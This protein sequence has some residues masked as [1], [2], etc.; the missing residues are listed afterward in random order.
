MYCDFITEASRLAVDAVS[1][2]LDRYEKLG[3]LYG[4]LGRVRLLAGDRVRGGGRLLPSNR[5]S[6]RET[7]HEQGA[8]PRGDTQINLIRSKSSLLPAGQNLGKLPQAFR[9]RAGYKHVNLPAAEVTL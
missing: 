7:E 6:L 1:H 9:A 2:S 5:R 8:N 4:I 3:T